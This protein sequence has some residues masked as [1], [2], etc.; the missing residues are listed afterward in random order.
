MTGKQEDAQIGILGIPFDNAVSF[1]KGGCLRALPH[2]QPL[3]PC[4]SR[5]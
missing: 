1:R 2:S 3:A 5:H 4:R